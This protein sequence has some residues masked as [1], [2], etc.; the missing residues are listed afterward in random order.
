MLKN[1]TNES[2][3]TKDM[4]EPRIDGC[5]FELS[6]EKTCYQLELYGT[7]ESGIEEKAA[8]RDENGFGI[9]L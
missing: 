1:K 5:N 2:R 9:C 4:K 8:I 3:N 6:E 7:L